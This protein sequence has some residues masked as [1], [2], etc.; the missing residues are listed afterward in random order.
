MAAELPPTFTEPAERLRPSGV[1]LVFGPG[2]M[3]SSEEFARGLDAF[4][5]RLGTRYDLWL[6][7]FPEEGDAPLTPHSFGKTHRSFD[8]GRWFSEVQPRAVV[9]ALTRNPELR[10][11]VFFQDDGV[12]LGTPLAAGFTPKRV[13]ALLDR[14]P[15]LGTTRAVLEEAAFV[16]WSVD[17]EFHL[18]GGDPRE[19]AWIKLAL[20][21]Q[22]SANAVDAAHPAH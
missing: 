22:A 18:I 2:T 6:M 12:I 3:P 19:V 14:V 16:G 4:L 8:A 15:D 9:A 11:L 21:G 20:R 7:V 10:P 17:L 13:V 5:D 1:E